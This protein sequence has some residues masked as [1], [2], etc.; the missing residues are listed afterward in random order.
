DGHGG[1]TRGQK[2]P[3]GN[4]PTGLAVA[5]INGDGKLDLLV[6]NAQGDV[7]TLLGNG[8]GTF[9]PYQRIGRHVALAV[10]STNRS[11]PE[12]VFADQ[13][14]DQVTVQLDEPGMTW[15]QGRSDGVLSP[16]A[17]KLVDLNGDGIQDLVVANSGGNDILFYAGLGDGRYAPAQRFFVG[18][19]P[20]AI[21]VAD[22]NGDGSPDL[23]V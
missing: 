20:V 10:A 2:L 14:L 22:L 19:D 3:A 18:T 11:Q 16:N 12:F 6:G 4:D 8:D 21:T 5:D 9:R 7:L 13:S 17:V 15:Q 23:V 1:F